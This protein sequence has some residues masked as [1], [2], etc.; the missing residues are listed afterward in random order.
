M[1]G[2]FTNRLTW[3]EIVALY[4]LT[5]PTS[6]ER[7]LAARYNICP[8]QTIDA[9]IEREGKRE[10]VPVRWG[11]IP[12]WWKMTAKETPSTFNA[13]AETV[14]EKPMFR[15]A[16][17]RSRCL[18]PASDYYEW[19]STPAGKQPWY[20]TT[21]DG[22]PLTIA[23]LWDEWKDIET[24]EPLKSCTMIVT[25]AN[26]LAAKIHDRM[27]VLLQPKDFDGW[28]TARAGMEILKP[29]PKDYLQVWP[30]SKHVNSSRAPSEDPALIDPVEA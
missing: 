6:P 3:R 18:I 30:V 28:L 19:Q 4:R 24:G 27:P 16:F 8:T 14:A 15:A 10:L 20:Y 1:C 22:S 5:A 25:N 26:A 9:V 2:R 13:R 17:N 12:S 23:G 29:A 7:N 21:R 11:L